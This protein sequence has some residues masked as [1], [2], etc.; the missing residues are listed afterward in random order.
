L[1]SNAATASWQLGRVPFDQPIAQA[2]AAGKSVSLSVTTGIQTPTWVYNDGAHSF[3]YV[4][5][6]G[7]AQETPIPWDSVFLAKWKGLVRA[8]GAHYQAN[9]TVAHVKLTGVNADTAETNLPHTAADL[10]TRQ[11]VGYT[12]TKMYNAWQG[13]ADTFAHAFPNQQMA[14][15]IIPSAFPDLDLHGN[16]VNGAGDALMN[17]LINQGIARYGSQYIVQNNGLS[18]FWVS[19]QVATAASQVD[20]AYQMLWFVTND[21]TYRMNQGSPVDPVTELQTAV[22]N[23]IAAGAHYLE[24]YKPD[25]V[26]PALQNVIASAHGQLTSLAARGSFPGLVSQFAVPG[27]SMVS[28]TDQSP[29]LSAAVSA[30]EVANADSRPLPRGTT[31]ANVVAYRSES[32][33][34]DQAYALDCGGAESSNEIVVS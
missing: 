26:N 3:H 17:Q 24:I 19:P 6:F 4:D 27:T 1:P 20:T 12:S 8:F 18:D 25:I 30:P 22:D 14:I 10:P 32:D 7:A 23:G 16:V 9:A 2:A 31:D 33:A 5:S 29:A 34:L 13:I 28:Q 15:M 21:S 11:R